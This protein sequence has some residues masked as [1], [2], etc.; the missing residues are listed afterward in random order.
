MNSSS[1]SDQN[2]VDRLAEEFVARHRRGEHPDLAEYTDRFPQYAEQ[3]R[4]LFP[5][6]VLIEQIKPDAGDRTG[7]YT[8]ADIPP[9]RHLERLGD[10]RILGEIGR[11]G[12][13]VVYEAEQ[14]SLG[15]RVALKVLPGHALLDPRQL[16]R[17]KREARAAARLHHT[18]IVPVFGVGEQ[19]GLHYYVMQFIRGQSLDGVLEELRRLRR[20]Q[21]AVAGAR[22][23]VADD[24]RGGE[25]SNRDEAS[26]VARSLLTGQFAL[27]KPDPSAVGDRPTTDEPSPQPEK[28]APSPPQHPTAATPSAVNDSPAVVHSSDRADLS[29]LS[30]SKHGY[31]QGVARVGVQVAEALAYAHGQ[32]ILH[33]DIKPANLLLDA[34]GNVWVADFGLAKASE[35]EDVTHTGDVVGTLRYMAPERFRGQS[36][37]RGDIYS[38]GLTLYELLV[39]RPAFDAA[40]RERL[41]RQVTEGEPPRPRQLEPRVPRDLETI[42]LKAIAREPSHRYPSAAALAEDLQRALEDRPIRARRVSWTGRLIR[43]GRRNKLVAGLLASLLVT[44]VGGFA[45]STIQWVRAEQN[46]ERLASELYTSDMLAVQQA[47]DAGNV[48][49]MGELLGRHVPMSGKTDWRGFEWDV[50]DRSYKR[51]QPSH[52]FQVSDTAWIF[53]ATPDGKTLAVL[54]FVHAPNPADDSVEV[55]LWDAAT[56][57]IPRTFHGT[58]EDFGNAITLTRDGSFF[59]TGS[60]FFVAT[61]S[62]V[63]PKGG[64][65]QLIRIWNAKTGELVQEGPKNDGA[66]VSMGALAFSPDG[67]KLLWGD[68]DEKIFLWDHETDEVKEFVGHKGL[69]TGVDFDPK[70]RWIATASLE[71]TVMLWD[72]AARTEVHTFATL[73]NTTDIAFSPDGRYLAAGTESG[74]QMWELTRPKFRQIVLEGQKNAQSLRNMISF[75]P[76]SRYLASGSASTIRLWEVESGEALTTL[77]GHSLEVWCTAFLDGGR[78]LASGGEDWTVKFWDLAEAL[79][80]RDVIAAHSR[81]VESL[82]F[83]SDGRTLFSGGSDGRIRRWDVATGGPLPPL[84]IP[85]DKRAVRGLAVTGDGRTLCDPR[86]GLWDVETGRFLELESFE[87]SPWPMPVA[88]SP[89][90]TIVAIGGPRLWYT[91]TGKLLQSLER[92]YRNNVNSLAF[93]PNGRILAWAG[94]SLNVRLWEV[95]KGRED[96]PPLVGHKAAVMSLAFAAD[97]ASL[98]SGSRDGTVILWDVADPEHPSFRRKLEGNTGAVWAVAYSSV[99]KT[100]AS[101]HDDGTVKLWDP[102]TGRERCT[103]VGHT[104]KVCSVAFSPDG[105]VLATGDAGGTIRLWRR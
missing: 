91:T 65:R 77:K 79:R 36:D 2:T 40:D 93:S 56:A 5:A 50:F 37:P 101:G 49:R 13:G 102:L 104:A 8:R 25:G 16:G 42:V 98:A 105:S 32:G 62:S 48:E 9:G 70:G 19:D 12:M 59:A 87:T 7:T 63:K 38:L 11:G 72:L 34:R 83:T 43:W 15:R 3:I 39:L 47:W 17:F 81:M 95:A 57:W 35:G 89:N 58:P 24:R 80:E 18:N 100:I 78:M 26:A 73:S 74:V 53:A 96:A 21:P 88:F 52:T 1:S 33:R 99:G 28:P 41:I 10:F 44:L 64:Q 27:H 29:S 4:D 31:W 20:S 14:E 67:R 86:T 68:G 61:G 84:P 23:V 71:G 66:R 69:H 54:V 46:A 97:G 45:V 60:S 75:S 55:T 103:L 94:E 92:S 30:N 51:A 6:L 90:G 85:E 22:P 82:A 76:D